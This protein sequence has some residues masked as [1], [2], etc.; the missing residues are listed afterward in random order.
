[1]FPW[2]FFH[3]KQECLFIIHLLSRENSSN[4]NFLCFTCFA[5]FVRSKH[6][7][8]SI[9]FAECVRGRHLDKL[10]YQENGW[11]QAL[12][13]LNIIFLKRIGTVFWSQDFETQIAAM[14]EVQDYAT[15]KVEPMIICF[16]LQLS[17]NLWVD[18]L[19]SGSKTERD[20][21][22]GKRRKENY[23]TDF[24]TKM[25][26]EFVLTAEVIKGNLERKK[27]KNPRHY[28]SSIETL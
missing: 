20:R 9:L 8:S 15:S 16:F 17:F 4:K 10:I 24:I 26:G 3:W 18:G 6:N 13:H 21:A 23:Q 25:V 2:L 28:K 19:T 14:W 22:E 11:I 12:P 1:M 5:V 27:K 7:F